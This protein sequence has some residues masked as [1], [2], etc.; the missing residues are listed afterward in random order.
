MKVER[1]LLWSAPCRSALRASTDRRGAFVC[2]L[3]QG[4]ALASLPTAAPLSAR[5]TPRAP[6]SRPGRSQNGNRV[7]ALSRVLKESELVIGHPHLD[8]GTERIPLRHRLNF[9]PS[10]H[11]CE[12]VAHRRNRVPNTTEDRELLLSHSDGSSTA[13]GQVHTAFVL[14]VTV[15]ELVSFALLG[16][17]AA[18]LAAARHRR[19]LSVCGFN[20]KHD[21]RHCLPAVTRR[22]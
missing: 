7:V 21:T 4:S 6:H 19:R 8:P 22:R 10:P 3:Q 15:P 2:K 20:E 1:D 17:G 18:G 16:V 12:A 9:Y 11:S 14:N 13:M 5:P